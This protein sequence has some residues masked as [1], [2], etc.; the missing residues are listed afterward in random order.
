MRRGKK[1][2]N[3]PTLTNQYFYSPAELA[4]EGNSHG[5]DKNILQLECKAITL[6]LYVCPNDL[7]ALISTI[8]HN[9]Y[10]VESSEYKA[11]KAGPITLSRGHSIP[12][13]RNLMQLTTVLRLPSVDIAW[14]QIRVVEVEVFVPI[15]LVFSY[16]NVQP[17]FHDSIIVYHRCLFDLLHA[18]A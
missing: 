17:R 14:L 15:S 11:Y 5:A 1:R 13:F 12:S 9:V 2:K 18:H 16:S 3:Q 4:T 10:N 8:P 6:S 7:L